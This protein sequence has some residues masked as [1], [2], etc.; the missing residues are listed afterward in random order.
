MQQ[1]RRRRLSGEA[2]ENELWQIIDIRFLN[3]HAIVSVVSVCA[4]CVYSRGWRPLPI[5]S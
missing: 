5:Y 4:V 2:E 1:Q 3:V